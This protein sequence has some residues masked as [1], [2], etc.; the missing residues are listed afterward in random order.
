[1]PDYQ[2]G[3]IYKLVS[4]HTDLI[5]IGSTCSK[6]LCIRLSQ[7]KVN[8]NNWTKDN[9]KAK[10]TSYILFE[11]GNVKI[12]L[13]ENF[14][15][16]TRDDLR[17]REQYWMDKTPNLVNTQKAHIGI[18]RNDYVSSKEYKLKTSQMYKEANKERLY[19]LNKIYREKNKQKL[20][21]RRYKKHYCDCGNTYVHRDRYI[22]Y[23]SNVHN[24]TITAQN[25]NKLFSC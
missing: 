7:H 14:P 12:I 24:T 20:N 22:H 5:Y 1:M 25:F 19:E 18:S 4:D 10:P 13:L 3:K 23:K 21:E 17:Q 15:C 16:K 6:R 11:L 9:T 2:L 8:F